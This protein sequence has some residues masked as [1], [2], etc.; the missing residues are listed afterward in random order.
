[1]DDRIGGTKKTEKFKIIVLANTS[2]DGEK[3]WMEAE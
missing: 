3:F 1:V 2:D